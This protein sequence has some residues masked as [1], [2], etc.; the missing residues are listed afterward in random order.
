MQQPSTSPTKRRA[1]LAV[2]I[3]AGR[4]SLVPTPS[5]NAQAPPIVISVLHRPF[6]ATAD[7]NYMLKD[8]F[9]ID[10]TGVPYTVE[11]IQIFADGGVRFLGILSVVVVGSIEALRTTQFSL[12]EAV[13]RP[14][15]G[16]RCQPTPRGA[17]ARGLR[18]ID[19]FLTLR[20]RP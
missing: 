14:Y 19:G 4:T 10:P 1:A 5:A 2:A 18:P 8:V 7:Q 13:E 12:T 17:G 11:S 20:F 6:L 15:S 16:R 3:L 9:R